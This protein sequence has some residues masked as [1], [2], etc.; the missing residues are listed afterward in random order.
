M[1][2]LTRRQVQIV[3]LLGDGYTRNQIGDDLGIT[4][5]TLRNHLAGARRALDVRNSAGLVFEAHRLGLVE[6]PADEREHDLSKA[7]DEFLQDQT[8]Y[9]RAR[10]G[11]AAAA[12]KDAHAGKIQ[13]DSR[14]SAS[15]A[16]SE[17]CVEDAGGP[18]SAITWRRRRVR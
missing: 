18:L 14:R 6:A 7:V 15:P 3:Q 12:A 13:T 17:S 4:Q 16:S 11:L 9:N 1:P 10:M 8:P 2:H 5:A